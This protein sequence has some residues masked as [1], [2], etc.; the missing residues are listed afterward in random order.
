MIGLP[1]SLRMGPREGGACQMGQ[2]AITR[3]AGLNLSE[4][5]SKACGVPA[6]QSIVFDVFDGKTRTIPGWGLFLK[7]R[8]CGA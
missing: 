6:G 7:W 2:R 3:F 1:P 5:D 4:S 8:E